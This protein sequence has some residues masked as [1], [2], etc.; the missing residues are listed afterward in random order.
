MNTCK[1]CIYWIDAPPNQIGKPMNEM[2][3]TKECHCQ[4]IMESGGQFRTDLKGARDVLIYSYSEGGT[5]HTGPDFGCI[6]HSVP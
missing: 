2:E 5:F 1:T 4:K 6:H 3:W